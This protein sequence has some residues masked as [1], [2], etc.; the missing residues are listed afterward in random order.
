MLETFK[1]GEYWMRTEERKRR[2]TTDTRPRRPY[3]LLSI[4]SVDRTRQKGQLP[5]STI[6]LQHEKWKYL[7]QLEEKIGFWFGYPPKA[8]PS[9]KLTPFP[10]FNTLLFNLISGP[11]A[12]FHTHYRLLW[13]CKYLI[14]LSER[15]FESSSTQTRRVPCY[16]NTARGLLANSPSHYV[17]VSL[18]GCGRRFLWLPDLCIWVIE[19]TL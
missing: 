11:H 8:T 15:W 13:R 19:A 3:S 10:P 6:R 12:P 7:W 1:L 16:A 18:L 2:K 9:F 17:S 5:S 4:V 14:M